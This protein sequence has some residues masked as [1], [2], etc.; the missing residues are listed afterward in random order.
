MRAVSLK[1]LISSNAMPKSDSHTKPTPLCGADLEHWRLENGL[2]KSEAADAFGLQKAKWEHLVNA[3]RSQ[4]VL[5]DSTVAMLLR[6]YRLHP[7]AAPLTAPPNVSEFYRF[8]GLEDSRYDRETFALLIGRSHASVHRL[9]FENGTPGRPVVRWIEAIKR[10]RLSA[11]QSRD[12][13]SQ[14]ASEV[15]GQQE[16]EEMRGAPDVLTKE[17]K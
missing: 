17:A 7:E 4:D 6:L 3:A 11:K 8:L 15:S 1:Y 9:L 14:V 13:M 2:T 5:S 16:I 12:V 10:L